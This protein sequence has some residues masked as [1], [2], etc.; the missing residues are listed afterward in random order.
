MSKGQR[1][2]F[3]FW[4]FYRVSAYINLEGLKDLLIFIK[5]RLAEIDKDIIF[6]KNEYHSIE[7]H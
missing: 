2:F 3:I 1:W 6:S 5:L 7:K 4:W